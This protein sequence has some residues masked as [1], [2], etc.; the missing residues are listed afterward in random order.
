MKVRVLFV[1]THNSVRSQ[2]AEGILRHVAGDKV[3]AQSAGTIVT[4]VNPIAAK[5]LREKHIDTSGQYSKSIE[6]FAGEKFDFVIT[7]CDNARQACP[8]LPGKH[9]KIHWS[10]EDPGTLP[11]TDEEKLAAFRKTRDLL[12]GLIERFVEQELNHTPGV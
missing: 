4:G 3:D 10:I 12:F 8:V 1:C 11:G 7:V 2:M 5:V 6:E 9:K